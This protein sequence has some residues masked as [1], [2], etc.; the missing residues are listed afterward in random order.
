METDCALLYVQASYNP[1]DRLRD[2]V[3]LCVTWWNW[4]P[5]ILSCFLKIVHLD[6]AKSFC[7]PKAF[8]EFIIRKCLPNMHSAR[9]NI[10]QIDSSDTNCGTD[11]NMCIIRS[12]CVSQSILKWLLYLEP[13]WIVSYVFPSHLQVI[14]LSTLGSVSTAEETQLDRMFLPSSRKGLTC[15]LA[16]YSILWPSSRLS[17]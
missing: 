6:S 16:W 11:N 10:K 13:V 5:E 14:Q 3:V 7:N 8:H 9:T 17:L 12:H 15:C 1:M 2:A 4:K